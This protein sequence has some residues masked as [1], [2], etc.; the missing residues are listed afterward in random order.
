MSRAARSTRRSRR[1]RS[2]F[3]AG[4][5][6]VTSVAVAGRV[7]DLWAPAAGVERRRGDRG[8][9]S[10]RRARRSHAR[11]RRARW[12]Q[13]RAQHG[14]AARR[15]ARTARC[16]RRSA[17]PTRSISTARSAST[18]SLAKL[19]ERYRAGPGRDRRRPRLP[20]PRSLALRV[21]GGVVERRTRAASGTGW[22]GRYLD[23]TVG[24]DD[25]LAG[26]VIGPGR[27]RRCS[28]SDSFATTIADT[29]GL[30]PR[31]PAW[32]DQPADLVEAWSKFAPA[33]ASTKTLVGQVEHAVRLTGRGPH[34]GSTVTSRARAPARLIRRHPTAPR[35]PGRRSGRAAAA[36]ATRRR[37]PDARR[38]ARRVGRSAAGRLRRDVRGLRHPPRR[39]P[40]SSC[41]DAAARRRHRRVLHEARVGGRGRSGRADDDVGVRS[42]AGRE[43][44]RHRPRHRGARTSSSAPE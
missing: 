30:Q 19:A 37:R 14:R 4:I 31:L 33:H 10:R 43:R 38:R 15:P 22:L 39:G 44:Q 1:P 18:R 20:R 35:R 9:R 36:V 34:D 2:R 5:G 27:R 23:G 32:I 3:L 16:G 40:A 42:P 24:F 26:V 12:R 17:S 6:A 29:T 21:D 7:L 13:R 25:P 11:R 8:H 28:A 41:A